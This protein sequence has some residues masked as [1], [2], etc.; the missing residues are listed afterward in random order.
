MARNM[1]VFCSLLLL[2]YS[3]HSCSW[4]ADH[5]LYGFTWL[6]WLNMPRSASLGSLRKMK[7]LSIFLANLMEEWMMRFN[8]GMIGY[9]LGSVQ[10]GRRF[11][12]MWC[13]WSPLTRLNRCDDHSC[14]PWHLFCLQ[15]ACGLPKLRCKKYP[16]LVHPPGFLG[17]SA[18]AA[19]VTC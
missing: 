5:T 9:H 16:S 14:K 4:V 13:K 12:N 10:A 15:L 8:S 3:G 17:F 2:T 1:F 11:R 19:T 18:T 6:R 7:A